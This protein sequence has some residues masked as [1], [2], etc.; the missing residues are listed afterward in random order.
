MRARTAVLVSAAILAAG[1]SSMGPTTFLHP[2]FNFQFIERVAVIP[3]EN[4]SQDQGAGQRTT[5]FF[6]SE[7]L[8]AQA[9]DVVEPGEVIRALEKQGKVRAAELT[10]AEAIEVGKELGVQAI[11]LGSIGESTTLRSGSASLPVVTLVARLVETEKGTTV[12]SNTHTEGGRGFW[13]TLLG[14]GGKS[15]GEITRRCVQKCVGT[16]IR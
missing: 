8:A 4:I 13:G 2:E 15:R 7:L 3:F 9:F 14:T 6:V 5:R 1:C 11:F 10:E 12:W 16:L